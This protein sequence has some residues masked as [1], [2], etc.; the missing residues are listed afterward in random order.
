M[1]L[2]P[3]LFR[4]SIC[5]LKIRSG[6]PALFLPLGRPILLCER[7]LA[8]GVLGS[9][10]V[11]AVKLGGGNIGSA[12]SSSLVYLAELTEDGVPRPG[13]GI[14]DRKSEG[15]TGVFG[16]QG[17]GGL[18]LVERL[19]LRPAKRVLKLELVLGS[20][21]NVG[22]AGR[23]VG[24]GNMLEGVDVLKFD[25]DNREEGRRIPVFIVLRVRD[26]SVESEE[27]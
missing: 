26:D 21:G 11:R 10:E 7:R 25:P 20:D 9:L 16:V 19:R 1:L 13:E 2:L 24:V 15:S 5:S 3:V 22:V 4:F 14:A 17:F 12:F 18:G 27:L 8:E 23:E 6:S